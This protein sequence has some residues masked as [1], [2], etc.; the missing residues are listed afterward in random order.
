MVHWLWNIVTHDHSDLALVTGIGAGVSGADLAVL[1][2]AIA[3]LPRALKEP[4]I[5]TVFEGLTHAEAGSTLGITTKAVETRV[6]R[7][8]RDLIK[9]MSETG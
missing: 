2:R 4:L 3:A 5:L 7:A 1:D 8:R 6:Y 9:S